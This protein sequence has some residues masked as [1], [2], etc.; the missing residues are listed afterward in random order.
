M[1]LTDL[2]LLRHDPLGHQFVL[3]RAVRELAAGFRDSEFI[4]QV[5]SPRMRAWTR[6]HGLP[7]ILVTES[8]GVLAV[9]AS[10]DARLPR[11]GQRYL[12]GNLLPARG[13]SEAR[14]L[15]SLRADP[16]AG[17]ARARGRAVHAVRRLAQQGEIHLSA[18][19]IAPD[20]L[21]ACLSIRCSLDHMQTRGS[22]RKWVAALTEL[23]AE[24]SAA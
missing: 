2:G 15:R 9:R 3:A 1:V 11:S 8:D 19:L 4:D 6:R 17:G 20:G 16:R 12:T 14:I 22:R 10:T 21:H 5:A 24:L 7:L 13:S 23:A 18:P